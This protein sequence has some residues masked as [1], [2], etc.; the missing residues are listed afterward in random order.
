MTEKPRLFES[1]GRDRVTGSVERVSFHNEESG[2]AVLRVK[3]KGRREPVTV[4]GTV[5]AVNEGEWVDAIGRWQSNPQYGVQLRADELRTTRPETREGLL[6]YLG[7]GAIRGVGPTMADRLIKAFGTKVFE[8][9]ESNP[10]N[11][12][13]VSGIGPVRRDMLVVSW[14]EQRAVQ[15]IMVFLHSHGVST[16]RAHRIY[17]TYGDQAIEEVRRDPYCLMRD[18]RG[19]GFR[20]ADTVAQRLGV[21]RDSPL[22]ARAGVEFILQELTDAGHCA[23][24]RDRL[25]GRTTDQLEIPGP[26]V[27]AAL[28]E[29]LAG[30][31]LVV[32]RHDRHGELVYLAALDAAE[33]KAA[34]SLSRL[35]RGRHPVGEVDGPRACAW[36]EKLL[37][38]TLAASQR[39]ALLEALRSKVMVITGG[40]GVGKTTLVNAIVRVMAVRKM[41]VVLCAPTGRAARRLTETSGREARTIHRLLEYNPHSG[42]FQRTAEQPLEGDVFV[43]DETSMV[44]ITLSAHLFQ[45]VPPGAALILVGD[46]DQLPSVG[47]G[48][49]LADIINS[50]TVPVAR[51]T[52]VFR[53]AAE[54]RIITAAHAVNA[55]RVPE[56][57]RGGSGEPLRDLYFVEA[58][59]PA[60]GAEM[61]VR[62][63]QEAIPRRFGL[64]PRRDVQV[65]SPMQRGELGVRNLNLVLQQALNPLGEGV[66]RYGWTYRVGD[67]VMQLENDYDREVFNGDVGWIETL[68]PEKREMGVRFEERLLAFGFDDL[69]AL[70][71]AYAATVHK[72]QGSEFPAVVVP[73][74]TQHYVLL[75]RNL[76]YTALTRARSLAVLLGT[77]RA[78]AIAVGRVDARRRIT[79]LTERLTLTLRP[80]AG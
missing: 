60:Q 30:G 25:I 11:L 17:K 24:P 56:L 33:R 53:Q 46:V 26:V 51:L 73:V 63:V 55:G 28:E 70:A 78:L 67:R 61:V 27:G 45:A 35:A 50:G 32:H 62:L 14:Q 22:R 9:I 77:R 59:D 13:Q 66:Q 40:P 10:D 3:V 21:A 41:D 72:A 36:V 38:L 20:T 64:D 42:R 16:A 23:F 5:P 7:S 69:D 49:V 68:D 6:K 75:Q 19:V 52:E 57:S 2:F 76:L 79:T 47:P 58:E 18:I 43:V 74:H 44:D 37:G 80:D 1:A 71:P 29:A 8:V 39:D 54:S 15:E 34:Y 65:L 4:V 48:N 12:L 31:R